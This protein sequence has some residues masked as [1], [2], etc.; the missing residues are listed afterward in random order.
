MA[1]TD[2]RLKFEGDPYSQIV[3][4][5]GAFG[6][7]ETSTL[8]LGTILQPPPLIKLLLDNDPNE[9]D[10]TDI[11]VAAHLTAHERRADITGSLVALPMSTEGYTPHTHQIKGI[12]IIDAT[13][14]FAD[15][16]QTGDRVIV[17]CDDEKMKFTILDRVVSYQ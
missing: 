4:A 13:I 14:S 7:N 15:V 16:L 10:A 8:S 1:N 11:Y 2:K 6:R 5:I 9:Y 12:T 3:Q 17:E